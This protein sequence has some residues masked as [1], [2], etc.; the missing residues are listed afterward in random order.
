MIGAS[1][2]SRQEINLSNV[3]A[4]FSQ[5]DALDTTRQNMRAGSPAVS[6]VQP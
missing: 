5:I 6:G 1:R 4:E 3:L 2:R